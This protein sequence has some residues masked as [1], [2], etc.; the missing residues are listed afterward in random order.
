MEPQASG[1][2]VKDYYSKGLFA[3]EKKNYDYAIELFSH[4]LSLKRD[5]ADAR[6]YLHLAAQRKLQENPPSPFQGWGVWPSPGISVSQGIGPKH[7][8]HIRHSAAMEP[9]DPPHIPSRH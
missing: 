9:A 4:A 8:R 2:Q 7:E 5:L 3:F 6:H 1:Q